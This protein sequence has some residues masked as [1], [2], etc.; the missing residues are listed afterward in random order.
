MR[1]NEIIDPT[2]DEGVKSTLAGL[3]MVAAA[4]LGGAYMD[5]QDDPQNA[6]GAIKALLSTPAATPTVAPAAVQASKLDAVMAGF[7]PYQVLK[8]I[9]KQSGIS[10]QELTQFV[11]QMAHETMNFQRMEEMGDVEY[12]KRYEAKYS[13]RRAK[14]LGNI[15]AGD[16]ALFKGRGFIQL[17]GRYNYRTAGQALNLPLEANPKLVNDPI[18]AAK[19]AVWYWKSRVRPRVT[20]FGNV[21]QATRPINPGLRGIKDRERK[22]NKYSAKY[23][24]K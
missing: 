14:I 15:K 8:A 4:G 24:T 12:F 7:T 10:G 1:I 6:P 13:P 22:F 21:K 23:G 2:I 3:G 5:Y 17:T 9:A 18:I 19:V 11:S 16:G 20:D